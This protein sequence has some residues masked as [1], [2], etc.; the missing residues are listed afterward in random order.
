M[1]IKYQRLLYSLFFLLFFIV[2]PIL[3][4]YALG[5]SF[6]IKRLTFTKTGIFV[7]EST[8]TNS[9]VYINNDYIGQ[10]PLRHTRLLPNRYSVAIKRDGFYTWEKQLTIT[11]GRTTFATD[12]QLFRDSLPTVIV[13]G[14]TNIT[15]V[16]TKSNTLLY[17]TITDEAETLYIQN[18]STAQRTELITYNPKQY[19]SL[20]FVSWSPQQRKALLVRTVDDF[21]FY[22]IV[23]IDSQ[24]VTELFNISRVDFEKVEWDAS[25]D[26][27]LYGMRNDVLYKIDVIEKTS[28]QILAAQLSDFYI[29]GSDIITIET[30]NGEHL[31]THR[32]IQNTL[33]TKVIKLDATDAYSFLPAPSGMITIYNT[34][35]SDLFVLR[36]NAFDKPEI[37]ESIVLQTQAKNI[38][39]SDDFRQ[40]IIATD[41]ELS[42][43][44]IEQQ[45][46]H[47]INRFSQPIH[48]VA[49]YPDRKHFMHYTGD[50]IF[51][52]DLHTGETHL[53]T[54]LMQLPNMSHI[55]FN[56]SADSL[57][58]VGTIGQ[59]SGV[60]KLDLK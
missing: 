5:Y 11:S 58:F 4:V 57:Y 47:L 21:N 15:A 23:D 13:S 55:E 60:Y 33:E 18:L 37:D 3:I 36:L 51:I 44:N 14:T 20:H 40:L 34:R 29:N 19:T 32:S 1:H 9:A 6:D 24:T 12:V 49:W 7:I 28:T 38:D 59:Q 17:S 30:K 50:T 27:V 45:S 53:E 26:L 22:V 2:A 52:A 43:H 35:T 8:P 16:S 25:S 41:F 46:A 39:W 54:P 56:R 48:T 42:I 31:L 10:T